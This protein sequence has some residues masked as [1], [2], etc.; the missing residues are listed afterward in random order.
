MRIWKTRKRH[1]R[2]KAEALRQ[3]TRRGWI[4]WEARM[5]LAWMALDE[6]GPTQRRY[7]LPRVCEESAKAYKADPGAWMTHTA[8]WPDHWKALSP[9]VWKAVQR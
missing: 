7:E 5:R 8:T 4:A 1:E 6:M 3:E 9:E 2:D